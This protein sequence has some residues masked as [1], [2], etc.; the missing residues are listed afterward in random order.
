MMQYFLLIADLILWAK[1]PIDGI[2]VEWPWITH[3]G[4]IVLFG[5]KP[6]I[7]TSH[8]SILL[9]C[10]CHT[11]RPMSIVLVFLCTLWILYLFADHP[12]D[13]YICIFMDYPPIYLFFSQGIL[14]L[15]QCTGYT[16][17]AM[18]ILV[19]EHQGCFL[20][21]LLSPLNQIPMRIIGDYCHPL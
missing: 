17:A 21:L 10:H 18:L 9:T 2:S 14:K 1:S 5:F 8:T 13:T 6:K 7:N 15:L 4:P 3:A 11:A 16:T 20:A 12:D 19:S